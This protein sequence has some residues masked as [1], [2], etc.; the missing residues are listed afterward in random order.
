MRPNADAP[1]AV[2]TPPAWRV[3]VATALAYAAIG[4][5]ALLLAVPPGYASPLYPPSGIALVAVLVYGRAALPGVFLGSCLVNLVLGAA[6][7][8]A[9]LSALLVPV[10]IGFGAMLQAALGA[11]LV[12]RLVPQ[13][14][15]LDS[16]RDITATGVWGGIVACLVNPVVATA[17]LWSAGALSNSQAP[18][19][20]L[21]WWVGD[22]LGVMIGAPLALTLV[23]RP[24]AAWRPRRRTVAL[25]LLATT[26][27]LAGATVAV[28]RWDRERLVASFRADAATLAA[29]A[30]RQLHEPLQALQALAGAYRAA[31]GMNAAMLDDAARW[32][33]SQPLQLRAA[34]HASRVP[35]H[36][37]AAFEARQRGAGAADFTVHMRGPASSPDA[38]VI[39]LIAPRES[40][41]RALGV[42]IMT[43]PAARAALELA[44]QSGE[45]TATAAFRLSQSD[46]KDDEN[47]FVLYYPL[48][49]G[50]RPADAA[51]RAERFTGVLF[52]TVRA[53]RL[54]SSLP[55]ND[56]AGLHWC[57]VDT[58]PGIE[59]V[60]LAGP[61]GCEDERPEGLRAEHRIALAARTLELRVTSTPAWERERQQTNAWVFSVAGLAAAAV[62]G[63]LLL[64]VTGRAHRIGLA[65]DERTAELR[66]EIGERRRAEEEM[67][68]VQ[69][70]LRGILDNVPIGVMF[71]DLDGRLLDTNPCLCTMLGRSAEELV[72]CSLDDISHPDEREADRQA[73]RTLR[74]GGASTV[75]R[76]TRLLRADGA[77]LHAR[78]LF[79]L[80]HDASGQPWRLAGVAEDITE[81]RR[82]EESERAL[83]RAE[84][85]NRAKTE[86]L[87]RMSHELRTPLNAMIG[88]AQLLGLDRDPPLAPH[89]REWSTQMLRAGW[90]LL[91][92]IND[93]LDL[94]RLETGAVQLDLR[95]LD[96]RS[97]VG[98][99]I[100]MIAT[101]A[102]RMGVTVDAELAPEALAV[103]A[104]DTRLK[105]VL[106]NLLSNAV[107]YNRPGGTVVVESLAPDDEHVQLRV[108]DTGLGMT[109]E[110]VAGL[111]QPYNRLGREQSTIEGTGIGLVISRRLAELM[112]G[113]LDG[114][115]TAGSGSVFT[116]TLPRAELVAGAPPST[117]SAPLE[118]YTRRRVHYI[119]DNETN[120]EVMRGVLAQ[121]PQIV[122]E[123]S[124]MGLDGLAAV[125]Q[126]RPHLILLDMHLPDISGLE[127]LR[128]LKQ[129]R[130]V[131][132]IPVIVVSADATTARMQEALTLGAA[133]YVTKPLDV[134]RFLRTVDEA[135][136]SHETRWGL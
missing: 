132:D 20:A 105:Q 125:R 17:A 94:A 134:R 87:S 72:R 83:H 53:E 96:L 16:V 44:R 22:T 18:V 130:D 107:K 74:A 89:Q 33:L 100:E 65:V 115:S 38:L 27:L 43:I 108:R 12:R 113:T 57:L 39:D 66:R 19:T 73:L 77:A 46:P 128:H 92:M 68:E 5:L 30:D 41:E 70:R 101:A 9:E 11:A 34:G 121:R 120:V 75:R 127:L 102:E 31:G 24:A 124:T 28:G 21:T 99:S 109:P 136:A 129:D 131:A 119:E 85:A 29:D 93:T 10:A 56:A 116:L 79:T 8:Q 111:F 88:F 81:H 6:R 91:A 122:L 95:P 76:Q 50:G 126:H 71:A 23:G 114:D 135:L 58:E 13:P 25:P 64:T 97:A 7:G 90:H 55:G 42:D 82:L 45:P 4:W 37:I 69:D 104:D 78:T 40:N 49:A 110:Q 106:T 15:V 3:A 103:L 118:P 14:L 133:Q 1:S 60:R 59:R 61:T 52:V 98:A 48:Y 84:A 51:T 80:L 63:A 117:I 67:R 47:G 2:A 35:R 123:V 26:L 36:A 112:G 32:W 54:L 62:L 86:F